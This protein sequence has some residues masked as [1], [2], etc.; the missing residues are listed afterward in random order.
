M[1]HAQQPNFRPPRRKLRQRSCRCA[2]QQV[3]EDQLAGC[4][5]TVLLVRQDKL[6]VANVG[7]SRAILSRGGQAI[8]LSREHRCKPLLH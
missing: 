8:Q 6:A 5:A 1:I 7:D 4:T 2:G 3:K